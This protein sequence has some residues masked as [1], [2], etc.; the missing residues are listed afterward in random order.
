MTIE[1][2]FD[3]IKTIAEVLA[4]CALVYGNFSKLIHFMDRQKAQDKEIAEIKEE[5]TLLTFG[6]LSCLKGLQEQGCNGPVTAAVE[7]IEKHINEK[8]HK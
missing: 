5:Q 7:K 4:L 1:L 8:A 6:I 3:A 2:N